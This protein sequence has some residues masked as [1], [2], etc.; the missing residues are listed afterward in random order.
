MLNRTNLLD[1]IFHLI[2][3][4]N[5]DYFVSRHHDVI[6]RNIAEIKYAQHHVLVM[7]GDLRPLMNDGSKFIDAQTVLRWFV[8]TY[9]KKV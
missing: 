3:Q 8:M 6:D 4:I 2:F 5:T 1:D 7:A 9:S